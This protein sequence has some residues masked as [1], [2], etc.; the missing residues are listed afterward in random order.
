MGLKIIIFILIIVYFSFFRISE[1]LT[2]TDREDIKV[3]YKM[4]YDIDKI[5]TKNGVIYYIDGGTLLGAVRHN[6]IIPWDDDGDICIFKKDINAFLKLKSEFLNYGYKIEK[7]WAGY[8]IYPINGK[9]IQYKNANWDWYDNGKT[10]SIRKPTYKFPF[11]DV[12]VISKQKNKYHYHN[13]VVKTHW[14]KCFHYNKDLLNL[15]RYKFNDYTLVGPNNPQP[16]L[17]RCYGN[18]WNIIG[19]QQY[20]HLN[21][22]FLNRKITDS[23]KLYEPAFPD[24]HLLKSYLVNDYAEIRKN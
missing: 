16:Y 23:T 14:P 20:D 22:Q 21:M 15:K 10:I 13:N 3:L 7:Y 9:D 1:H 12:S 4:L 2:I 19:K 24:F 5:L 18:D 17:D 8:K 6:G 11:V